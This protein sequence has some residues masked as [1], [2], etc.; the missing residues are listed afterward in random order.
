[1]KVL[2]VHG[3]L[4]GNLGEELMLHPLLS[5][6]R[7]RGPETLELAGWPARPAESMARVAKL[8]DRFI[9]EEPFR[10]KSWRGS[11]RYK[12][13]TAR[14][15]KRLLKAYD[16]IISKPGPYLASRDG[17]VLNALTDVELGKAMGKRVIISN[18]SIGPLERKQ[19]SVL[20]K[21]DLVVAREPVT[22][23]YLEHHG[24]SF[25][26]GAD[27]AFVYNFKKADEHA[28]DCPNH[29]LVFLRFNNLDLNSIMLRDGG[30]VSNEEWLVPPRNNPLALASSDT[31]K[32]LEKLSALATRLGLPVLS[33]DSVDAMMAAI[34]AAT[35]V[36]SDRYHPAVCAKIAGTPV[37][38][39]EFRREAQKMDG[40]REMLEEPIDTLVARSAMGLERVCD[41]A[42]N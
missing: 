32:D 20:R 2:V 35:G 41:A 10:P 11:V 33:F 7:S 14:A 15:R 31:G 36:F 38:I 19:L 4:T 42:F 9:P 16:V 23:R 34:R 21:A 22:A 29:D 39:L 6:L 17:R 13:T 40:L 3:W 37:H 27:P 12:L 24:C 30:L 25:F 8:V 18:H 5:A 1:M 26:F 28:V